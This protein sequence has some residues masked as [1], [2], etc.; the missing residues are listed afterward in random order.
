MATET[1]PYPGESLGLPKKGPGSLAGWGSR[2]GALVLDEDARY[3]VLA[4]SSCLS[5]DAGHG[6]HP[7]HQGKHDPTLSPPLLGPPLV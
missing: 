7:N 3:R 1:V 4:R 6:V 2:L 5:A